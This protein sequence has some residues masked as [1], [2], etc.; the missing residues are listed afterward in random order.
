MIPRI[1]PALA[2]PR[3]SGGRRPASIAFELVVAYHPSKRACDPGTEHEA[4]DAE[5]QVG[6]RLACFGVLSAGWE[7]WLISHVF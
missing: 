3:F 6:G 1:L 2:V 4:E 7:L 5:D